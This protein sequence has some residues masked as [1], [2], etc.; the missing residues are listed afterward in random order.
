MQFK[1]LV[2]FLELYGVEDSPSKGPRASRTSLV[3]DRLLS[4]VGLKAPP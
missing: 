1:A 3:R 4:V 2:D